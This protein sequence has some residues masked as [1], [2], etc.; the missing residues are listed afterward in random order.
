MKKVFLSIFLVVALGCNETAKSAGEESKDANKS[1][2]EYLTK[3]TFLTKV[4]NYEQNKEWKFAGKRPAIIEFYAEW[5]G[6]CKMMAPTLDEMSIKYA[7]KVDIYKVNVD[8]ERELAQV[9]QVSG[10]PTF[11]FIPSTGQPSL[12]SGMIQRA[13]FIKI[14]DQLSSQK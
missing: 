1:Q 8:K 3:A 13:D 6:P 4:F 11:F 10:I 2:V 5:C 7:G 9:F 14:L 12:Q